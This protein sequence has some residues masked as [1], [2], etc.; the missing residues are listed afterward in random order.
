VEAFDAI[1]TILPNA[2][3]NFPPVG[4][5]GGGGDIGG[6]VDGSGGIGGLRG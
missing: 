2:T 1:L 6:G 3:L 4:T 5:G